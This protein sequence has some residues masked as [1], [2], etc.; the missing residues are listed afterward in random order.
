MKKIIFILLIFFFY[1]A[2]PANAFEKAAPMDFVFKGGDYQEKITMV[3]D[4]PITARI[5]GEDGV[6]FYLDTK[7]RCEF[8]L[9]GTDDNGIETYSAAP[10]SV[11]LRTNKDH[12]NLAAFSAGLI[13]EPVTSSLAWFISSS[14]QDR[15]D[16][17]WT[18]ELTDAEY[19]LIG[20]QNTITAEVGTNAILVQYAGVLPKTSDVIIEI[21]DAD[22]AETLIQKIL[23]YKKIPGYFQ[24]PGGGILHI[25]M[26]EKVDGVSF[27]NYE[28]V[29][30]PTL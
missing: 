7:G 21:T 30:E 4:T 15:P 5:E 11:K 25:E 13:Y 20:F 22:A 10:G 8:R 6:L 19:Q 27:L 12:T 24:I 16:K 26:I 14:G 17:I 3:I 23:E 29:K 2:C 1:I 18:K 28:W 9:T